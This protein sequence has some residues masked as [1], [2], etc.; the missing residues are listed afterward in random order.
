MSEVEAAESILAA[1]IRISEEYLSKL[2]ELQAKCPHARER[3]AE[4]T[5]AGVD[6]FCCDCDDYLTTTLFK[7]DEAARNE[8]E[9]IRFEIAKVQSRCSHPSSRRDWHCVEAK[10]FRCV[11]CNAVVA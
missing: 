1:K 11:D 5:T 8:P 3:R 9:Q 4:R 7:R 6:Y 10:Q 2:R